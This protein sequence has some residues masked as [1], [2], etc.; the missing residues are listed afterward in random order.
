MTTRQ[1]LAVT[2]STGA[3]LGYS[4]F[5]PGTVGSLLGIPLCVLLNGLGYRLE[6]VLGIPA[7]WIYLAGT[8]ICF[9]IGVWAAENASKLWNKK[10]PG[11]IVV[12]EIAGYLITMVCL[13]PSG[14]WLLAAFIVARALDILKVWPA[15]VIDRKG[16]GGW[17]I[18]LDDAVSGIQG[19][20]ILNI[21]RI[22][23]LD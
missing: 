7:L 1:T 6:S 23:L 14:Q 2:I 8:V 5:A 20:I 18:M 11:K 13:P 4:P 22:V 3:G 17:G 10:D 16:S 15:N 19:A 12:D 9:G 21:F